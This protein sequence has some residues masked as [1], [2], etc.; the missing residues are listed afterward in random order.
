M[1][2]NKPG[3]L[4]DPGLIRGNIIKMQEW[5]G[6]NFSLWRPQAVLLLVPNMVA[7]TMAKCCGLRGF[8]YTNADLNFFRT[9][10]HPQAL[11]GLRKNA[12]LL[13]TV[14]GTS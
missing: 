2:T 5:W 14:L 4:R 10:A 6:S 11:A 12:I 8:Y 1:N 7:A 3:E 9:H 13:Y